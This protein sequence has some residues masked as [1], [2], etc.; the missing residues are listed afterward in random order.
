MRQLPPLGVGLF[1]KQSPLPMGRRGEG[2]E[3]RG[4]SSKIRVDSL[5][6][7]ELPAG[8]PVEQEPAEPLVGTVQTSLEHWFLNVIVRAV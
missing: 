6:L 8:Q 4:K 1:Q 5:L 2:G 7:Q 3:I